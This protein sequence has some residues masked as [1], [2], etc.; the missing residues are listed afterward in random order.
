MAHCPN[1]ILGVKNYGRIIFHD[2]YPNI[3][4]VIYTRGQSMEY[5][6]VVRPG[7]DP[8]RI[9]MRY[10]YA[11]KVTTD[12]KGNLVIG[13][14][15]GQVLENM[16]H[17]YQGET[18]IGSKF[19]LSGTIS[20][21]D[22]GEYD[23]SK[24]LTID[25]V[26]GWITYYG[27]NGVLDAATSVQ[28]D[29]SGNIYM[30][31]H[32]SSV[33]GIA[34]GGYQN[35]AAGSNNI[36]NG[37]AY[38]VKF[39]ATGNRVWGTYYG[40]TDADMANSLALDPAGDIYISGTT[41]STSVIASSNV[42][43]PT[44]PSGRYCVAFAAKF[45]NQ[46]ARIWG[47]Y[48]GADVSLSISADAGGNAYVAM[49]G[50]GVIKLDN[51]CSYVFA[52]GL[53]GDVNCVHLDNAGNI[54]IAGNTTSTTN[55]ASGG[56]Q[57]TIGG[58][59]DA[60]L[61]K[62]NSSGVLLWSTY[63]GG[64]G[65]DY[66]TT[67]TT[68]LSG[69]VYL[70]G[71]TG[72]IHGFASGGWMDTIIPP[73]LGKAA[74]VSKYNS[75]GNRLW[76]SYYN[77]SNIFFPV[78]PLGYTS[79]ESRNIAIC[80]DSASNNLYLTGAVVTLGYNYKTSG[81]FKDTMS[82]S[83]DAFLARIS[84]SGQLLWDT[85][86]GSGGY[87]GGLGVCTYRNNTVY[88]CGSTNS[89]DLAFG[90]FQDTLYGN[91]TADASSFLAKID[92]TMCNNN[93]T[94]RILVSDSACGSLTATLTGVLHANGHVP[95]SYHWSTAATTSSIQAT[96][97]ASYTL[98]I[99][100][101]YGCTVAAPAV[102]APA[103]N[104]CGGRLIV[105][106]DSIVNFFDTIHVSVKA[107]G[108]DNLFSVFAKLNF[109]NNHLRL[110]GSQVGSYLGS[111]IINQPAVVS[112]GSIDF[113][114]TKT[115]GQSGTSGDGVVYTFAFKAF[116]LPR[117]T[118]DTVLPRSLN[119]LFRL[120][121]PVV[122][123]ATGQQRNVDLV[124]DSTALRYYVPVWPGD[125]NNDHNVNVADVL[126]IGYF[127]NKTGPSR[128]SANLQWRA[129]PSLLWDT[130]ATYVNSPAYEVFADGNGD[131]VI[132]LADQN[133]IGFNLGNY[134]LLPHHDVQSTSRS[135]D[136][137][138][139]AYI[140]ETQID[141][142]QIPYLI[143][144]S[145]RLGSAAQPVHDVL[146]VAFDLDF[147]PECIDTM[148]LDNS[149]V[150]Y[151]NLFGTIGTNCTAIADFRHKGTGRISIGITR[152]GAAGVDAQ[153][154]ELATVQFKLLGG[155]NGGWF[156]LKP[157]VLGCDSAS[158]ASISLSTIADSVRVVI[159]PDQP[160]GITASAI[161]DLDLYPNPAAR[162]LGLKGI[163]QG[164]IYFLEII[165]GLGRKVRD[166][167]YTGSMIDI[168]DLSSGIYTV[169]IRSGSLTT[170]RKLAIVK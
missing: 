97:G 93:A 57:N 13:T 58:Q 25:P 67:V 26:L 81:G 141:S 48:L 123:D 148:L 135:I 150:V 119:E 68:D 12:G 164:R 18:T 62:Y 129:Q 107:Q 112:G 152:Y 33:T 101:N 105:E 14:R 46:G 82:G 109:D 132:N 31:G 53:P 104:G 89:L 145:I 156:R 124:N 122:N 83:T 11:E 157:Y 4:W 102:I 49:N 169:N 99:T 108:G 28:T 120:S 136:P 131:G 143:T 27:N 2:V 55:V 134:H 74:F 130:I 162:A 10:S 35:T 91:S 43:S 139:E 94:T 155:C 54:Y 170:C 61:A 87:E 30:A 34:A 115:S 110:L 65:T 44:Y 161:S 78:F 167:T 37:D 126:P 23:H 146:G 160:G 64:T 149:A 88:V 32:T 75:V 52:V 21:F 111:N 66:G 42:F 8:H 15:L 125:L 140:A 166:L 72:S 133:S 36:P 16:P 40:G 154:D 114:M 86:I 45:T 106:A 5:D 142:T 117:L 20:S 17:S 103:V 90:G 19:I 76:C 151:S 3:D 163:D 9:R 73:S 69:N 22:I 144:A 38:F 153:G 80:I 41:S 147:N 24:V 39:D 168:G 60:F 1:G 29:A 95:V 165:D 7:G 98:T 71:Y 113:G 47:T 6:F 70:G 118:F 128:P 100:D 51:S 116:G 92:P 121:T 77:G 159:T 56:Y 127:Y 137:P 158:G 59:D 138:L 85:Y 63:C 84:P 50:G 96:A 79:R